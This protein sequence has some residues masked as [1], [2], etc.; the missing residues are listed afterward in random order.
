MNDLFFS[1]YDFTQTREDQNTDYGVQFH[2]EYAENKKDPAKF[3]VTIETSV[4]NETESVVVDLET[5]GIF[6]I[7]RSADINVSEH[8]LKE[9]TVAIMLPFIRSQ[10]SLLTTQPGLPPIML[11][12]IN[13]NAL[14]ESSQKEQ[15]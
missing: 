10:I 5:V 3:R 6:T 8:L 9:N 14:L 12:P 13:V 1:R 2:I 4:K 11:P 7:D 15:E